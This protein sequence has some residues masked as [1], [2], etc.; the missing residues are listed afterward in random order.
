VG[1]SVEPLVR[2][3][4]R[5]DGDVQNFQLADGPMPTPCLDQDGSQRSDR[6][7]FTVEFQETFAFEN[8]IDFREVFV[9]VGPRVFLD[10]HKVDGRELIVGRAKRASGEAARTTHGIELVELADQI[11]L[12]AGGGELF[13]TRDR[14]GWQP[15][16]PWQSAHRTLK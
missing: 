4:E 14:M 15:R 12:H 5:R 9:I 1:E 7:H 6:N 8:D 10:I 11:V 16:Q 2:G 13:V 3:I